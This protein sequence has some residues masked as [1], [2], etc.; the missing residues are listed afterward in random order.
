MCVQQ[1]LLLDSDGCLFTEDQLLLGIG[2]WAVERG[3]GEFERGS[4]ALLLS[5]STP[6]TRCIHQGQNP[7]HAAYVICHLVGLL[8]LDA[9]QCHVSQ[10]Q[11]ATGAFQLGLY[12]PQGDSALLK[13]LLGAFRD[14]REEE[15][16]QQQQMGN[17]GGSAY[18]AK[19]AN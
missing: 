8:Q 14:R 6:Y 16:K 13:H 17:D 9:C 18:Q 5:L 2:S 19:A 10:A 3:G 1:L 15:K 7:P 4:P 12:M 11:E